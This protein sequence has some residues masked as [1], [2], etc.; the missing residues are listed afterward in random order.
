M[1]IHNCIDGMNIGGIASRNA[2]N[3]TLTTV[4]ANETVNYGEKTKITVK[5][6]G[7]NIGGYIGYVGTDGTIMLNGVNSIGATFNLSGSHEE[8]NVYGGAIGKITAGTFT[9]NIGTKDDPDNKLTNSLNTSITGI[10]ATGGNSDSGGLIGYITSAE[11]YGSRVVNINNLEYDDCTIGNAATT[12]G[13][14]FLGYAWLDT[15]ANI[16]GLTV[17]NG[18]ISNASTNN[19]VITP[20]VGVMCYEATGKWKV[21]SLTI[22]K[23]SMTDGAGTS[24]G[25]LVNKAYNESK[26][27]YLDVLNTGYTLT[28]KS[29]NTGITLPVTLGFYDE[30]AAYSADN[31]LKGTYTENST[32]HG[33]GVISINMNADRNGSKTKLTDKTESNGTVTE[34]GTGTYQNKLD[35]TSSSALENRVKYPNQNARYY[36]NLD[37]MQSTNTAEN[38][39]LWSVNQYAASNISGNFTSTDSPFS[40]ESATNIDL[41]GYSF[42]PVY[43]TSGITLQNVNLTFDYV[44]IRDAAENVFVSPVVTDGF[45]RDPGNNG[46][47]ETARN[48]HFL[49][50]SG[51]F[52]NQAEGTTLTLNNVTLG[53]NF[54]E[55]GDYKGVL[56]S[57]ISNGSLTVNSLTLDGIKPNVNTGYLLVNQIVR[58]YTTSRAIELSIDNVITTDKYTIT[59]ASNNKST[60]CIAKSL[61]GTASGSKIDIT[62]SA[63]Q[64]DARK[65]DESD[66]KLTTSNHTALTTA[67]YTVNSIFSA[68]TFFEYI[69]TNTSASL[70]Y[71]YSY[72][73]DWKSDGSGSRKV[74]YGKEVSESAQW[75]DRENKYSENGVNSTQYTDPT[76]NDNVT[77][78]Y[79]FSSGWLPY[80]ADCSLDKD[81]NGYYKREL[82]VNVAADTTSE[83]CGTYNDPYQI[84]KGSDLVNFAKV[85]YS[86]YT[87]V[88]LILPKTKSSYDELGE[89]TSGSRWCSDNH[90]TYTWNQSS[91]TFTSNESGAEAWDKEEVRKYLENAYYILKNNITLDGGN[92]G[93]EGLGGDANSDSTGQYAFRGVI[94]GEKNT[95]DT[96]K[97][98]ITNESD[99]PLVNISN[100]CVIKDI[101]IVQKADISAVSI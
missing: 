40:F 52:I 4:T 6:E 50:H 56:V 79:D 46:S 26:G 55:V 19:T 37:D 21:D 7:K 96:P 63:M 39:V 47:G 42:Y 58:E 17:T 15:T 71:N 81:E 51:L 29:G 2:G 80:V 36:Y 76:K 57:G 44:G 9:V 95:D 10:T 90:A 73:E 18:T 5:G 48:Q 14:G 49:M 62:L 11:S 82:K 30:I 85:M 53:G 72:D 38:V 77:A 20:N 92:N 33:A 25:M 69:N 94:V 100:G 65:A 91:N 54:L 45:S 59:D 60:A 34:N 98:T 35:S 97:W 67:Y 28:K 88:T 70:I 31:V 27:L 66:N 61:F 32:V 68:S 89:V 75:A 8:W 99:N 1:D 43:F 101:N 3:V 16:N 41:S 87:D 13:G 24:L 86:G 22:T 64:L 12:K 93:Y 78:E 23:M 83:G 74:T 84:K